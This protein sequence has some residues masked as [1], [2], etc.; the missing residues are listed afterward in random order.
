MPQM[1]WLYNQFVAAGLSSA[2]RL[3]AVS[4]RAYVESALASQIDADGSEAAR[5]R[6]AQI[7][8]MWP[9]RR[10]A[11]HPSGTK[12]PMRFSPVTGLGETLGEKNEAKNVKNGLYHFSTFPDQTCTELG[13]QINHLVSFEHPLPQI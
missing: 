5:A 3:A 10:K 13:E 4:R 6:L 9:S 7:R 12:P 2:F 8:A 1:Q 11:S